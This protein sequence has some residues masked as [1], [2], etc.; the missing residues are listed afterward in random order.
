[1][2]TYAVA[3]NKP[4]EQQ[5]KACI[6]SHHLIP[7]FGDKRLD[8]I[9]MHAIE[10]LKADLLARGKSRKRVNNVLHTLSKILKY[11]QELE[12]VEKVPLIR[13]LKVAPSSFDFFT[14]EEL[15]RLVNAA[16]EE[17]E[18]QAAIIV[19]G[20]AGLRMGKILALQW[21]DIDLA[22]GTMTV[23]SGVGYYGPVT[24][25]GTFPRPRP[26]DCSPGAGGLLTLE[27]TRPV[28]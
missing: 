19:A 26:F 6:L 10:V 11:A 18:W 1:M 8:E 2:K 20:D 22:T 14:Y 21:E 27:L 13:T 4:S 25:S 28:S 5:S 12:V 9:K 3:N 7:A 23:T 15:E 24:G 16:R 17:P